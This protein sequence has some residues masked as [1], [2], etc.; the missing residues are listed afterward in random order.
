MQC[1]RSEDGGG[2]RTRFCYDVEAV[3]GIPH[4]G[5]KSEMSTEKVPHHWGHY[6]KD[7]SLV[8][9]LTPPSF[10]GLLGVDVE[11]Q[12]ENQNCWTPG[13]TTGVP[14]GYWVGCVFASKTQERLVKMAGFPD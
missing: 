11:C 2:K 1:G 6:A 14:L 13:L 4:Q 9:A 7:N 8:S 10:A 5:N 12:P 3:G